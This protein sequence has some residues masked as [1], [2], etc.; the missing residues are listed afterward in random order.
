MPA[1]GTI[2]GCAVRLFECADELV[3]VEGVENGIAYTQLFSLPTWAALSANGIVTFVPLLTISRLVIAVLR[4]AA[5][6]LSPRRT[7]APRAP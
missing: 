3:L 7:A 2:N 6:K 4:K 1:A 5:R